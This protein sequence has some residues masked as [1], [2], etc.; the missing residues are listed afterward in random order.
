MASMNKAGAATRHDLIASRRARKSLILLCVQVHDSAQKA[1][2]RLFAPLFKTGT[3]N[4]L[5]A[6]ASEAQLC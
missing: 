5:E 4:R 2:N 3:S 6:A 1:K